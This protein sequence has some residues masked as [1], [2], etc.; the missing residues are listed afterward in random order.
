MA[1][2]GYL[3]MAELFE[4]T[5]DVVMEMDEIQASV[6]T[7]TGAVENETAEK[8]TK[9]PLKKYNE[10][11]DDD[12]T[13]VDGIVA[14]VL[15]QIGGENIKLDLL[16]GVL[17]K[18][19]A[20]KKSARE[21]EK[22]RKKEAK[23]EA[24]QLAEAQA[25]QIKAGIKEGDKINYYMSTSKVEIVQAEV[26][27]VTEKSARIEVTAD[28]VVIF[29]GKEMRAGEV[30]GLKLGKKSVAFAKVKNWTSAT[31]NKPEATSEASN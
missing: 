13:T 18:L 17:D 24:K 2:E 8:E 9:D 27:K 5:N 16:L 30:A 3:P 19:N 6:D 29:K 10:L 28:S 11:S 7:G 20:E 26:I 14:S 4:K 12:K 21:V 31:V 1:E 22:Q 23:E 15:A 25:Q